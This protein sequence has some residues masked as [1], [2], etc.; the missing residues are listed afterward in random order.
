MRAILTIAL[1][2]LACSPTLA[3]NRW[4]RSACAGGNC[5]VQVAQ[6]RQRAVQPQSVPAPTDAY[7]ACP[8]G[9]RCMATGKP[10]AACSQP[11]S[12]FATCPRYP[13]RK[14]KAQGC[15]SGQCGT[16]RGVF[17]GFFRGGR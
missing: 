12:A 11:G 3:A 7:C 2:L 16:R 15:A 14:A 17:G 8:G 9:C 1:A 5:Q 4:G 10:S 6:P 13:A